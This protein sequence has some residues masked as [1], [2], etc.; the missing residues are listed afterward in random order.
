MQPWGS[1]ATQGYRCSAG[2][3]TEGSEHRNVPNC[4]K[5]PCGDQTKA[6]LGTRTRFRKDMAVP[7][8][9]HVHIP[10]CSGRTAQHDGNQRVLKALGRRRAHIRPDSVP[11][12]QHFFFFFFFPKTSASIAEPRNSAHPSVHLSPP[13]VIILPLM[14]NGGGTPLDAHP[15]A[16]GGRN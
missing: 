15:P 10:N 16:S 2:G 14:P 12:A 6:R 5:R 3:G 9:A 1:N 11:S 7:T 13:T 8:P 4:P